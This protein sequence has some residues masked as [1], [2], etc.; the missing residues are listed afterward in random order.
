MKTLVA[1]VLA[2]VMLAG[3]GVSARQADPDLDSLLQQ[4]Q[5]AWNKGDAK[6][7]AAL[8][9][10]NA[11]RMQPTGAPL[12]GRAA[13]EQYFVQGFAGTLKG[14]KLSLKAGGTQRVNADVRIMEG[15]Y[16]VTG[17]TGA[18]QRGR[19]LNTVVREGGQWK[20]ASVAPVADT[21]AAK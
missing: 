10:Q 17:G 18:P 14:T 12:V 7:L 21:P 20:L 5:S 16:E 9:S 6:S 1:G 11:V 4:Y 2:V 13:I 8:Y 19:Y 15:T 3:A